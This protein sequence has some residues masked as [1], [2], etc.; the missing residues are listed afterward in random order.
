MV[1]IFYL[2]FGQ[3]SGQILV[4]LGSTALLWNWE[5]EYLIPITNVLGDKHLFKLKEKNLIIKYSLNDI[6]CWE[7]ILSQ[8]KQRVNAYF[9]VADSG[10]LES[11]L[12]VSLEPEL[13][14]LVAAAELASPL[15]SAG[16]EAGWLEAGGFPPAVLGFVTEG[17]LDDGALASLESDTAGN[18]SAPSEAHTLEALVLPSTSLT[19]LTLVPLDELPADILSFPSAGESFITLTSFSLSFE[20]SFASSNLNRQDIHH[21]HKF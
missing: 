21:L 9:S 1:S 10:A 14:L 20:D 12:F 4:P 18:L 11:E 3:I 17:A 15:W 5:N 16:C 2:P 13:D 7:H 8:Y 6:S 19:T